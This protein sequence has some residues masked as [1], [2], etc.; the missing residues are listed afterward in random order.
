MIRRISLLCLVAP[1]IEAA[2]AA[3]ELGTIRTNVTFHRDGTYEL[4]LVVDREHLPPGFGGKAPSRSLSIEGMTPALEKKVGGIVFES[5]VGAR[6]AFDGK[7]AASRIELVRLPGES[8][9]VL[10]AGAEL[11]VRMTGSIPA[12]ARTFTWSNAVRLGTSMLT[13]ESEGNENVERQWLENAQDS[14]PFALAASIVPPTRAQ[15]VKTYLELGFTHILPK[16]T[17]HILFVLGI[18]L[19]STRLK[20]V[21]LQVTVSRSRTRSRSR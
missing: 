19:L 16:G 10:T 2:A 20:P 3:H 18:F 15:V 1:L 14:K 13:L 8:D 5:L 6:P 9:E 4:E 12:G 7:P 17:D 21:I 11:T